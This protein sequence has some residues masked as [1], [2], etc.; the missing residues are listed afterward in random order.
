MHP[1]EKMLRDR[2]D[3]A[4]ADEAF[5]YLQWQRAQRYAEKSEEMLEQFLA[6]KEKTK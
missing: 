3:T 4:R 6:K 5:A 1:V 2:I